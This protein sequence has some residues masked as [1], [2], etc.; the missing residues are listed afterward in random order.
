LAKVWHNC[1]SL[2]KIKYVLKIVNTKQMVM[3]CDL[4]SQVRARQ[5]WEDFAC[6]WFEP[7]TGFVSFAYWV[8]YRWAITTCWETHA[9][10]LLCISLCKFGVLRKC[11]CVT[12]NVK[13]CWSKNVCLKCCKHK[14]ILPLVIFTLWRDGQGFHKQR[15]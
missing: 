15:C 2:I 6:P 5:L 13:K 3:G 14:F 11:V 1:I 7:T 8:R 9:E 10:N 12:C 4:I